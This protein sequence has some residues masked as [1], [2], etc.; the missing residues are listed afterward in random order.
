MASSTG[1]CG[2]NASTG[3]EPRSCSC[4][5]PQQFCILPPVPPRAVLPPHD[6]ARRD[7]PPIV[8]LS[9][10]GRAAQAQAAQPVGE[11]IT[12]TA[13]VAA[14]TIAADYLGIDIGQLIEDGVDWVLDFLGVT[15]C[16]DD[17]KAKYRRVVSEATHAELVEWLQNRKVRSTRLNVNATGNCNKFALAEAARRAAREGQQLQ[18]RQS[19]DIETTRAE[20][21]RQFDA[22]AHTDSAACEAWIRRAMGEDTQAGKGAVWSPQFRS[23]LLRRCSAARAPAPPARS[24]CPPLPFE[25]ELIGIPRQA[26]CAG[27]GNPYERW[28]SMISAVQDLQLTAEERQRLL[29]TPA[30]RRQDVF[31]QIIDSRESDGGIAWHWWVLGITAIAASVGITVW[32]VKK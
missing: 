19:A 12:G 10:I 15:S 26:W 2:C 24:E 28:Q 4:T 11:L 22:A 3:H 1:K 6:D 14:A 9:P 20:R 21:R 31:Q 27:G 13:L 32:A 17:N 30:R 5:R 25:L 23:E 29:A 8:M 7:G 18:A 16:S